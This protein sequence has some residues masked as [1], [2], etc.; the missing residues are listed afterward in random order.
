M[1]QTNNNHDRVGYGSLL[2]PPDGY[3]VSLAVG[4][5]YS[6][7][8]EALTAVCLSLGLSEDTDSSLLQN[9]ITLLNALQKASEKIILFCEAGQIKMPGNPSALN[10]LL[11][12]IIVPVMLPKAKELN[13]YPAFHPKTWLI[14]YENETGDVWYRFAVLS[15][16]LTFDR[17]WDICFAMDSTTDV[18]CTEKS[19]PIAD[20]L[21]FLRN[22]I[23]STTF[24]SRRKRSNLRHLADSISA[25]S[26]STNS[27]EF[28][29]NFE[30]M[31]LGIGYQSYQMEKDP[32]FCMEPY[33]A[34]YSF[35][36]LAAFSP[37]L[38]ASLIENWNNLGHSLN[39]TTRVLITRKSE[40]SKITKE[41]SNRFDIYTLK[42]N[43]VDGEDAISDQDEL[44]QKQDIHAKIYLRKKCSDVDLYLG[45]MNA[46]YSA[47]HYNVEMMIRLRTKNRY[48][49]LDHFLSDLFC[50]KKDGPHNPFELSEPLQ[51][52]ADDTE[53]TSNRLEQ[54]VK[55]ICR[56]PMHA[57]V[58][59][60][61]D[62]YDVSFEISGDLPDATLYLTPFRRN[63]PLPMK[64][65]MQFLQL[66]LLQLSEFYL[67]KVADRNTVIER[68][69]MVPTT[70][71]PES[72]E[73]AVVNSIVKD[74][75]SFVEYV[76]FVLGDQYLMSMMEERNMK[77]SGIWNPGHERLPALYEKMLR[78]S[79]DEPE[80]LNEIGYLLNM[81]TEDDIIPDEF[82]KLYDTFRKTLKLK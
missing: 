15:R 57:L 18:L 68:I 49:N 5:T 80:R 56:M 16:N 2:L 45:S 53:E 77:S 67:L 19:K 38:S 79:M 50:G 55:T 69:I 61:G 46:T 3:H 73:N 34:D 28:G 13:R 81:V 27:K 1:F 58:K 71:M 33:S 60:N 65:K 48:Y 30:I 40:L 35:H 59:E 36:E 25:V 31:P 66:D 76:S 24:D 70:G 10:L 47:V 41:Q 29:E 4:T 39:G 9:S 72:R 54:I 52:P 12:K 74:K 44:K 11:E 20:F 23:R 42:D 6:L 43:I 64:N 7:D 22:Q 21:E 51:A 78:V 17:S 75:K 63:I 14:Q 37:F 8:L 32:L 82:R 62:K 26:F